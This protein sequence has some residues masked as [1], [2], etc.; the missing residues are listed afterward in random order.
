MP[1]YH[2]L[3][4]ETIHT[5]PTASSSSSKKGVVAAGRAQAYRVV[6]MKDLSRHREGGNVVDVSGLPRGVVLLRLMYPKSKA[7]FQQ[8]KPTVMLPPVPAKNGSSSKKQA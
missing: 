3:T 8:S 2:N 1:H 7:V 6:L 5:T 4:D